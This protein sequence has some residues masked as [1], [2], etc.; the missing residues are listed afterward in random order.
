MYGMNAVAPNKRRTGEA[1]V[2]YHADNGCEV[3]RT[4]L[5]CPLS[6][7]KFDD[8]A[9]FTTYRR[10][11]RDFRIA[12]AIHS[13]GLSI[14]EAAQRFSLT[15]RTIFRVLNRCRDAMRELTP[16]EAEAFASLI[17]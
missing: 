16:E 17:A 4:C 2:D 12:A 6:R 9:W 11:S 5:E 8:M 14:K 10:L 13:E 1:R 15:P 7:C 3:A